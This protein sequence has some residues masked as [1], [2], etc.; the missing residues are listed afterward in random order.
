ML[1]TGIVASCP[2]RA[3]GGCV[4]RVSSHSTYR[5]VRGKIAGGVVRLRAGQ[6]RQRGIE[7]RYLRMAEDYSLDLS[8]LS[9]WSD[10]PP[11]EVRQARVQEVQPRS[12]WTQP[13]G[14]PS[15]SMWNGL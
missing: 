1:R 2:L 13:P 4:F 3:V 8:D 12:P 10:G 7:L 9:L 14:P 6:V 5:R 15:V 11:H